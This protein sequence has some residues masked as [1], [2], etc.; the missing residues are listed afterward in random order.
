MRADG[1]P[2]CFDVPV[3]PKV[4]TTNPVRN[5]YPFDANLLDTPFSICLA[6]E[7]VVEWDFFPGRQLPAHRRPAAARPAEFS[8]K[9]EIRPLKQRFLVPRAVTPV[10]HEDAF[11]RNHPLVQR[12]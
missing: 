3:L 12:Y 11:V 6:R 9:D 2:R 1:E 7:L 4:V 10:R 5:I 8:G